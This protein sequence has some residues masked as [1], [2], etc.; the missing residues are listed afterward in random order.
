MGNDLAARDRN[1]EAK[2]G[3]RVGKEIASGENPDFG[4]T[5]AGCEA[6]QEAHADG[7]FLQYTKYPSLRCSVPYNFAK[8]EEIRE[9]ANEGERPPK[10]PRRP[11]T[12]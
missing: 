4:L 9:L 10:N 5:H 12:G 1:V 2:L 3:A 6:Y 7:S 8:P 11:S